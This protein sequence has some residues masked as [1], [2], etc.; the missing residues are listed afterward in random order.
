MTLPRAI[1][2]EAEFFA[3]ALA[4][5]DDAAERYRE[6][7]EQMELH[8]NYAL[9]PLFRMMASQEAEHAEQLRL[10]AIGMTLPR[11][12]AWDHAWLHA[13]SPESAAHDAVHYLMG[14]RQA[15]AVALEGERRAQA[16]LDRKSTR[17]NSSHT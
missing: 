8:H 10:R 6:L 7:A 4:I 16:F 11:L 13:E 14:P 15:L 5:E 2:T 1:E 12:A 9:V 17:L 3:H